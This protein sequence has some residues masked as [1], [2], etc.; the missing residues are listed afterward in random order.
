MKRD[1]TATP[2]ILDDAANPRRAFL[3]WHVKLAS[4]MPPGGHVEPGETPDEAARREAIEETGIEVHLLGDYPNDFFAGDRSEGRMIPRPYC[5]LLE[6]IPAITTEA[7]GHEPEHEHID[8]V[9]LAIPVNSRQVVPEAKGR[10]F[11]R[12]E[13]NALF[14]RGPDK[15]ILANV[16]SLLLTVLS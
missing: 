4:W 1:F 3:Q 9:Y 2:V 5:V 13:I 15:N 7:K 6:T 12:R 16:K 14:D 8:S 10:W 11:T